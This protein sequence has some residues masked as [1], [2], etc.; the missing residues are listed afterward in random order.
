MVGHVDAIRMSAY[1]EKSPS[2]VFNSFSE[3]AR[4]MVQENPTEWE[5]VE[6]AWNE[7]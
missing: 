1:R 5:A 6:R 3:F 2:A 7:K 4:S